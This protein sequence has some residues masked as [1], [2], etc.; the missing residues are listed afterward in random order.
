MKRLFCAKGGNLYLGKYFLS[1]KGLQW[2]LLVIVLG[3]LSSGCLVTR[4]GMRDAVKSD[5]L[6]P[7]QQ[8]KATTEVRYQELEEQQRQ[9]LGRIEVLENSLNIL[10]A[11]RSG[12]QAEKMQEK[13]SLN[14]RMQIYQESLSKLENQYFLLSQKIDGLQQ[15]IASNRS[16]S[17]RGS[18]KN[19]F[20]EAEEAFSKK[21]WKEAIVAFEKY[22]NLNPKGKKYA[23]ATYK[24]GSSFAE[25]NMKSEARAFYSEVVEKF[26]KDAWAK[27]AQAKIKSLK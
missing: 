19:S 22:R 17:G 7:E 1:S 24:I 4:Q 23:E 14:E 27:R 3:V 10:V 13:A 18:N 11:E 12:S 20:E 9:L 15:A 25:L 2:T 26:P 8:Q 6:T 21:K 5:S 16:D